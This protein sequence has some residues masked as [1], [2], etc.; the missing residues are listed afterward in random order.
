M[1]DFVFLLGKQKPHAV[2]VAHI[3]R[4]VPIFLIYEVIDKLCQ[5]KVIVDY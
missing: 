1:D 2:H 3:T 5:C 4:K